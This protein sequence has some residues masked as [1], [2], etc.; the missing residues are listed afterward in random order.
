[1][2]VHGGGNFY[3]GA[4]EIGQIKVAFRHADK[5]HIPVK[6]AVEGEVCYLGINTV[7]GRVVHNNSKNTVGI[8]SNIHAPGGVAAVVG[9]QM[10][11]VQK[12]FCGGIGTV[13]FQIILFCGRKGIGEF[14]NVAAFSTEVITVAVLA[15]CTVPGVGQGNR[16]PVFGDEYRDGCGVLAEGPAFV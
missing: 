6:T 4:A 5:I 9:S 7:V 16:F 13:D 14:A 1:M 3:A 12:Y 2:F 10:L 8:S 15:V 11:S